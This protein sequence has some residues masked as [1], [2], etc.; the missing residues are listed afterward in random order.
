MNLP[1]PPYN[2]FKSYL[3]FYQDNPFLAI[4]AFEKKLALFFQVKKVITFTNCFTAIS[5]A[6]LYATKNR[7]KNVFI[8]GMAYRRTA[9][10]VKWAGLSPVFVDN[11]LTTLGMSTSDL[12]EKLK[13]YQAGVVLVQH[14]MVNLLDPK[15]YI[16]LGKKYEVPIIFD[17]V[18]ATGSDIDGKKIGNFGLMEVFSLHPSKVINAAE[19]GVITFNDENVYS[20]FCDFLGEIGLLNDRDLRTN[21]LGIEPVHAVMG[22]SS[23][24]VFPD[25][26]DIF[27][28]HY[29]KYVNNLAGND[30]Y[31]IIKYDYDKNPNFKSVLVELKVDDDTF[32]KKLLE[33]MESINIGVRPYYYPLH[34][35]AEL[36]DLP[37]AKELSNRYI[38]LPIGH[39]VKQD[40]IDYICEKL[41]SFKY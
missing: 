14:P 8:A 39:S 32:R 30:L 22:L 19:G 2:D 3:D 27:R 29:E 1:A 17:S 31:H 40:D 11:D 38:F 16:E 20:E 25:F 9:D 18:E 33:Y 37:N 12:E 13:K 23:L 21:L 15:K 26:R 41:I 10:I 35:M 34:S 28:K 6:L 24:D 5:L 7:T 4:N 36:H